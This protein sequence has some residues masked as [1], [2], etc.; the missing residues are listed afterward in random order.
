MEFGVGRLPNQE[1][2]HPKFT[3]SSD[4]EIG[5][6]YFSRVQMVVDHALIDRVRRDTA[7]DDFADRLHH[8]LA[9]AVVE[10]QCQDEPIVVPGEFDCIEYRLPKIWR[11]TFQTSDVPELGALPVQLFGFSLDRVAEN[12][13]DP[14]NFVCGP[15][16]VFG[17]KRPERQILDTDLTRGVGDP[18][19]ILGASLVPGDAG[20]PLAGSPAAVTVHDDRNMARNGIARQFSNERGTL[21]CFFGIARNRGGQVGLD[22]HHLVFFR[23]A[24]FVRLVGEA[25]G[26]FVELML[27]AP[28]IIFRK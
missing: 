14:L 9:A 4:D 20:Q 22:L 6:W 11:E 16:P 12:P 3:R 5:I 2:A 15:A 8:F 28:L 21:A 13:H 25:P 1:V 10:S 24:N 18:A 19:D 23:L 26:Q 27:T 7:S 17:R